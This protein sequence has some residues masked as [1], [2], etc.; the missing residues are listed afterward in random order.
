M[1]GEGESSGLR[2]RVLSFEKELE[3]SITNAQKKIEAE[4]LRLSQLRRQF[5]HEL[6]SGTHSGEFTPE[7]IQLSMVSLSF[8]IYCT[9]A[10]L[11]SLL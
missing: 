1:A 10:R 6:T 11:I 2:S 3:E 4:V 5:T 9:F 8:C 7:Q